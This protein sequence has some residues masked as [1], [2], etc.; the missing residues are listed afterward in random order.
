MNA[1]IYGLNQIS[2]QIPPDILQKAFITSDYP[3][4]LYGLNLIQEI[5][6]KVIYGRV[7]PDI[8][9]VG[10]IRASIDLST[11]QP[12]TM[13]NVSMV[14]NVPKSLTQGK[15]IV[16]PRSIE[17]G[18]NAWSQPGSYGTY[19]SNQLLG[20]AN[21]LVNSVSSVNVSSTSNV[22]LIG[23]NTILVREPI[24]YMGFI[25]LTCYLEN[26]ENLNSIPVRAYI[27]FGEMLVLAVKAYI[28]NQSIVRLDRAQIYAGHEL[29][30]Y[31]ET[32][33]SYS[34]ANA[35][36]LTMLQGRWAKISFMSDPDT[37]RDFIRGFI[38]CG[39]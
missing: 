5:K 27:A 12:M 4:N 24:R 39:I 23:E 26:D 7:F 3:N 19:D 34:E 29:G 17:Y 25:S 32:V 16:S 10:G 18:N 8:N 38:G 35:E 14:Y 20:A 6:D 37:H 22:S 1:I 2:Q 11:L 28:Y 31:R 9:I 30:Q 36:Y 15:S 33:F 13:D 21:A